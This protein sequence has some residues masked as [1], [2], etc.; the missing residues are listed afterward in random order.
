MKNLKQK[1]V[2]YGIVNAL[3]VLIAAVL[4]WWVYCL[5]TK[6]PFPDSL[7]NVS[8]IVIYGVCTIIGGLQAYFKAKKENH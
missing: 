7:L 5:I 2:L 6:K 4:I 3:G 8:S 1:P